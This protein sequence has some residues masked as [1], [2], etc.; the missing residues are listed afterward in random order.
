M[1]GHRNTRIQAR[2][3][4]AQPRT[5]WTELAIFWAWRNVSALLRLGQFT[6]LV[7]R[8]HA[9]FCFSQNVSNLASFRIFNDSLTINGVVEIAVTRAR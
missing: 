9:T 3:A 7:A 4:S 2:R 5:P 6:R 1:N 8:R